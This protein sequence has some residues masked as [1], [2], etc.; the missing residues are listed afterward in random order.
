[1]QA[2]DKCKFIVI[3][4]RE[5]E[6]FNVVLMKFKNSFL[7]VQRQINAM[8]R[9]YHDFVR[10]YIDNLSIFNKFL[11]DHI[12]HLHAIFKLLNDR[13]I[14]LS[15]RKMFVDYSSVTLLNQKINVF[16]FIVVVDKI[17][18]IQRLKFSYKLIDLKMYL[19]LIEWLRN[20][21][22]YYAQKVES[23]QRRKVL[24][25]KISSFNKERNRKFYNQ[26][27]TIDSSIIEELDLYNQL[28]NSFSQTGFLIH[29]NKTRIFYIDIDVFKRRDFEIMMYHLK[30]DFN[31]KKFKRSDIELVFFL[32]RFLNDVEFRYWFIEL[33][34]IELI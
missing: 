5:Q 18:A 26:R 11:N 29:F 21:V 3:S 10:A 7:Y 15:S 6:Q 31:S 27:T 16:E 9:S 34:M 23:L 24:L 12:K 33:K 14:I 2:S 1:M 28:Q 19:S 22:L 17:V 32:N 25:I 8:L 13:E 4:H 30:S 20:Y